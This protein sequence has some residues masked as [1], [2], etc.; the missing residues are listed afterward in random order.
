MIWIAES[1]STKCDSVLLDDG[2]KEMLRFNMMGFN[3]FFHHTSFIQRELSSVAPIMKHKEAITE[4]YFY[5]AGCS[6]VENQ[7]IVK[8]GLAHHL[9]NASIIVE[10]DLM[11]SAYATY[12]GKPGISCILGTGS[13]SVYFDGKEI[14]QEVP[15]LGYS[16]GDEG[17]AGHIGRKLIA[18]FFYK[19][20]PEEA[21]KD[22]QET[23]QLNKDEF[24]DRIYRQPNPNVYLASFA[25]FIQKYKE[26]PYFYSLLFNG[27]KQFIENMVMCYPNAHEQPISYV[28]SVAHSYQDVLSDVHGHMGLLPVEQIIQKP[29]DGLINY[30]LKA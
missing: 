29:L 13:N 2:G 20:L 12:N 21:Q 25:P 18:A 5:G 17:S 9:T 3:P 23:Y 6:S 4:V 8:R 16:I 10:H 26:E 22:F 27:F 30:H 11:A 7:N 1:G 24:L 15:S 19:Q 28:G 14:Y